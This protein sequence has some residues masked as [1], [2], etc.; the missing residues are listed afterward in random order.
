[1]FGQ[2]YDL[3]TNVHFCPNLVF[4]QTKNSIF[5]SKYFAPQKF[6]T[7]VSGAKL[8]EV[9]VYVADVL[10]GSY[11]VSETGLQLENLAEFTSH[12]VGIA[13]ELTDGQIVMSDKTIFKTDPA[14]PLVIIDTITADSVKFQW[15]SVPETEI[16][17]LT[18]FDPS[19][20]VRVLKIPFL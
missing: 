2:Y 15:T 3:Y 8:Y 7:L 11:E 12:T 14:P 10:E 1:M 5:L 16:Y 20:S 13:A 18:L 9:N 4:C 6:S 17:H 19:T